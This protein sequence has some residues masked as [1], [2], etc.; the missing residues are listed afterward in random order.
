MEEIAADLPIVANRKGGAVL[1]K[2]VEDDGPGA[3]AGVEQGD[4]IVN[5]NK[6]LLDRTQPVRHLRQLV[7]GL[8]PGQQV[9]IT[10]LRANQ[11]INLVIT[12]GKRPAAGP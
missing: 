9:P 8:E 6:H 3:K 1:V 10:V 11:S 7:M 2:R 12:L 4:I 5:F